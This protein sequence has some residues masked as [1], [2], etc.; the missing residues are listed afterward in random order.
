M[1]YVLP[2]AELHQE[3]QQ[4]PLSVAEPLH[5]HISGPN[6]ELFRFSVPAERSLIGLGWYDRQTGAEELFDLYLD[7]WEA[8]NLL[9]LRG[10]RK[11]GAAEPDYA[12]IRD[13]LSARLDQWMADSGDPFAA[14]KLPDPPSGKLW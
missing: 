14:G 8:C 12:R 1:A 7:P 5:A 9:A 4:Q 11:G 13:D 3:F 2:Q 10:H 6:A